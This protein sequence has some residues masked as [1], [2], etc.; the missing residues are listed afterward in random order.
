MSPTLPLQTQALSKSYAGRAVVRN[1]NL[2]VPPG[3]LYGLLGPNGAGKTTTLR[4]LLALSRPTSGACLIDGQDARQPTAR[5][6]VAG[7]ID[8]PAFYPN[9]TARENLQ[10]ASGLRGAST[11]DHA[12]LLELVRLSD[13]ARRPAR[14][15]S[16]GMKQRLGIA[17]TLVGNPRSLILD[18]PQNGLDPQGMEEMRGL[19]VRLRERGHTVVVSSHLLGE[20]GRFA[21]HLGVMRGGQ[22]VFQGSLEEF[23]AGAGERLEVVCDR[24]QEAEK[25]LTEAGFTLTRLGD[26]LHLPPAADQARVARALLA[27]GLN[28]QSLTRSGGRLE[29]RYFALTGVQA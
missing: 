26:T 24:A 23:R 29:D 9:L 12:E 25:V 7:M 13:A 16:L 19:L 15:Y 14:T 11:A 20:V 1:V 28:W 5:R 10:V 6:Q 22:L 2:Q 3:S 21:T 17:M 27:A 18:E 4:C 8:S